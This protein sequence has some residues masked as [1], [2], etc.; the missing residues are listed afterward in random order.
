[1][2]GDGSVMMRFILGLI[3]IGV[4]IWEGSRSNGS[5]GL[6]GLLFLGGMVLTATAPF[7]ALGCE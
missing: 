6:G 4:S 1:M 2:D 5:S 7:H 3:M